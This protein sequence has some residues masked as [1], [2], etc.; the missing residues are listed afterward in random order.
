MAKNPHFLPYMLGVFGLL[1]DI[2]GAGMM[3]RHT[4][5]K[6]SISM[7][8]D[9]TKMQPTFDQHHVKN[10]TELLAKKFEKDDFHRAKIREGFV[11]I[12]IGFLF[13]LASTLLQAVAQ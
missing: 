11:L 13:Q 6:D 4:D 12:G 8:G 5:P 1:F 3:F 10:L 7:R 9:I 2:L